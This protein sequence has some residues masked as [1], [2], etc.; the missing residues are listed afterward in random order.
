MVSV[1]FALATGFG[2]GMSL[3]VAIGAQ[4][5]FVLRQGIRRESVLVVVAICAASDALLI[6]LGVGGTGVLV[7]AYPEAMVVTGVVGGVFLLGYGVLAAR[8]SLTPAVLVV[9]P[10]APAPTGR[11]ALTC[12]AFTWLNPHVYLDTVLLLG[13]M[14]AGQGRLSWVFAVGAALASLVWFSGLGFGARLLSGFFARPSSWRMLDAGVALSMIDLGTGLL[15][16][17]AG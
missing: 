12:L 4:N 11:V 6:A 15:I 2:A 5:A 9:Q 13:G 10:T 14:T 17:T 1:L 16:R 8:R 7:A 3:I